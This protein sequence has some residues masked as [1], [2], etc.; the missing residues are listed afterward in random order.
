[1]SVRTLFV[2][3]ATVDKSG[4]RVRRM[5]A[6]IAPRYDLMNHLLSMNIDRR[7][8]QITVNALRLDS[9]APIADVCTGTGDLAIALAKKVNGRANV[10]ATDF[11]PEMLDIARRKQQKQQ[12]SEANL[13]FQ[14]A[15]TQHLPIASDSCQ[16]ITVAFGIRNVSNTELGLR[17]MMRVLQP[18]G[19]MAILEFSKP[20]LPGLRHL[21]QGYFSWIL[22]RVGQGLANN[23]QSAYSYLP[24]SV[25]EF[26]CGEAM[27]QLLQSIGLKNVT[28]RPLT[29]GI[30][31]LYLGTK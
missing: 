15:D 3:P 22:P 6:E 18:G 27:V 21:Y 9:D 10:I 23:Q 31:S 7:W 5:F 20:T 4:D 25:Q 11:C 29:F 17:E 30:A 2:M 1:M 13:N 14:E 28:C 8:R 19:Q 24:Q 12:V 26:P 16:A